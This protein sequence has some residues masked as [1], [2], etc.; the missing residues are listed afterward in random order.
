MSGC[1]SR[2]CGIGMCWMAR[3]R[4]RRLATS[5]GSGEKASRVWIFLQ[6]WM[7][8]KVFFDAS[9]EIL[10]ISL[11]RDFECSSK[12][13]KIVLFLPRHG[14]IKG[15]GL[16]VIGNPGISCS[17]I[18]NP[19]SIS[20]SLSPLLC[21]PLNLLSLELRPKLWCGNETSLDLC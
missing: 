19:S 11:R 14:Y 2:R 8:V 1:T 17:R 10:H 18:S 21:F 7:V 15:T 9:D 3:G 12:C 16:H 4:T 5:R 20:L 6:F 13:E